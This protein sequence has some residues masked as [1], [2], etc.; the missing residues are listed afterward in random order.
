MAMNLLCNVQTC[1]KPLTGTLW[2]TKCSHSFCEEHAKALSHKNIKCPACN[3]LLGKRFD[4]IRQNSNP[5]EDF[6]SM[7]LVGLRPEIVFDIAMRAISFW[8]YQVEMELKFQSNSANHLFDASEKAKNHQ[9]TLIK[10]LASAKRTIEGNEKQIND[11]KSII[12][13]LKSE[14]SYRD[15]HLKKVQ[16]LLLITK[17][18]SP[19]THSESTDIHLGERNGHDAVK[20]K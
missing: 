5:G 3:T 6:K 16:N 17:S 14:I 12:K 1:R 20:K 2:V 19:D 11:Q 18:K 15:Q 9:A 7:L 10:Q 13:H 8:N 4:V